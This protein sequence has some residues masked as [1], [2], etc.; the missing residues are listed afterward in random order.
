MPIYLIIFNQN[1]P[2]V[3]HTSGVFVSNSYHRI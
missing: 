3:L 2:E 1:T